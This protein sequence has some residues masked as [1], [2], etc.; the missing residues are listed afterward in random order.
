MAQNCPFL[1][2]LGH[3]TTHLISICC[4]YGF[5]S[6]SA[7]GNSIRT[8]QVYSYHFHKLFKRVEVE[9]K[10]FHL[11]HQMER[12]ERLPRHR[13][14]SFAVA[15]PEKRINFIFHVKIVVYCCVVY[16][17]NSSARLCKLATPPFSL[18]ENSHV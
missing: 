3:T 7:S 9:I 10:R 1:V 15:Q 18:E 12:I 4:Y 13:H 5:L 6:H 16:G 2:T 14:V 8:T 11:L 17:D